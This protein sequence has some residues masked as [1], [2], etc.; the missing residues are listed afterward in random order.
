MFFPKWGASMTVSG[1]ICGP[2]TLGK[3][4]ILALALALPLTPRA[5]T[6]APPRGKS[7]DAAQV[8]APTPHT[9]SPPR[10]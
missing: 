8:R 10:W 2:S 3:L 5:R 4:A 6:A 9:R 1:I 7:A